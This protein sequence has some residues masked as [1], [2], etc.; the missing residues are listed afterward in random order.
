MPIVRVTMAAGRTAEQ[1]QDA[2]REITETIARC[3][4]AHAEHVYVYF[5]DVSPDEWT[6]GGVTITERKRQRGEA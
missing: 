5:E 2:A 4:N 3:C 1:K 6:V